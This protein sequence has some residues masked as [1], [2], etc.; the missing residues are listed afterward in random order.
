VID[1]ISITLYA[2][3]MKVRYSYNVAL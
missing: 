1:V 2:K 3:D